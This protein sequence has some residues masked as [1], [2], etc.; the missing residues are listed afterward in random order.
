MMTKR[1][2]AGAALAVAGTC[3]FAAP[4]TYE[5]TL[6]SGV[7]RTGTAGGLA[8]FLDDGANVDY[9]SFAGRIGQTVTITVNRL[10]ANFDPGLTLYSGTTTVD[11]SLFSSGGSYGGMT[12]IGSLDD[13]HPASLVP[14]PGG[15]PFGSFFLSS[16][17]NYTIAIGGS[18]S[19]DAGQYPYRIGISLVPEP[20]TWSIL[21][22][23]MTGLGLMRRRPRKR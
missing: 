23:G 5:G 21:A 10:N 11:T 4:T 3:A 15:D 9:W 16:N 20:G 12:F 17:G 19:T 1:W 6:A 18:L 14:G 8:W 7:S 13:E 22:I 2:F